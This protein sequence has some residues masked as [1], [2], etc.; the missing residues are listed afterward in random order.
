MIK[1]VNVLIVLSI[2]L[3]ILPTQAFASGMSREYYPPGDSDYYQ[4]KTSYQLYFSFGTVKVR[5]TQYKPQLPMTTENIITTVTWNVKENSFMWV[6]MQCK[7]ALSFEYLDADGTVV[8]SHTRGETTSYLNDGKC[9]AGDAVKPSDFNE[10]ANQ[11]KSDTFGG[12]KTELATP[13]TADGSGGTGS[14]GYQGVDDGSG[15]G[16]TDPGGDGGSGESGDCPGCEMF[17]CPGCEMFSCPGWSDFM[18]G[19]DDI[20]NAIPPAPNWDQVAGKIRDAVVPSLISGIGNVIGSAPAAPSVPPQLPGT[21]DRGINNDV[22]QMQDVPGLG[23]AG[24]DSGKIKDEAPQIPERQDPTGGFDLVQDPVGSMPDLP[25]DSLP[26]PGSTDAGDWG[27]NKPSQP[28]NPVPSPPKDSGDPDTGGAPKPGGSEATPPKPGDSSGSV[29]KPGDNGGIPPS[30]GGS[31]GT[32][33]N[34]GGDGYPGMKDYKP[35][36]ESPD[37]SGGDI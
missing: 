32:P 34:P 29:P 26:K 37:G 7:G 13:P 22:P 20:K 5:M 35:T 28:D 1:K 24:F 31:G 23:D 3:I 10:G 36:P 6:D 33:P 18:G 11:Y 25:G 9:T 14:T 21:D 19:L 12:T 4:K 16:G 15:S 17:S 8:N 30:P 27:K 2:V